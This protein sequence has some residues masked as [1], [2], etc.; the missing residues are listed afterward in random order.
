M[1]RLQEVAANERELFVGPEIEVGL[2]VE[3]GLVVHST[4]VVIWAGWCAKA[5]KLAAVGHCGKEAAVEPA[6]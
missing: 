6:A 4:K 2:E 3:V 5:E 1:T